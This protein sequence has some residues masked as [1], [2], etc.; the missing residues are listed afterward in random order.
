MVD[1]AQEPKVVITLQQ[2]MTFEDYENWLAE[3]EYDRVLNLGD[4]GYQTKFEANIPARGAT[5][6]KF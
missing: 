5:I 4:Y 6:R 3:E 1:K 2:E